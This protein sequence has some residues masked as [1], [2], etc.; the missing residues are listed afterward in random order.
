M[1]GRHVRTFTHWTWDRT[2]NHEVAGPLPT[3]SGHYAEEENG[4]VYY[5]EHGTAISMIPWNQI[6]EVWYK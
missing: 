2:R 5:D 6:I 4:I 1:T 3:K